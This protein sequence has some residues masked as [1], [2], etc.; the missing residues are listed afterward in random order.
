MNKDCYEII[1]DI[2]IAVKTYG[3]T[4]FFVGGVVRDKIMG[5]KS[6]DFD[7]E[8]HNITEEKLRSIL[9]DIT[10]FSEVGKSFG[11]FS[12]NLYPIDIALPRTDI[13]SGNGHRDFLIKTLPD[14]GT[15]NA[16]KRRDFTINSIMENVL[17][18][19]II[20][21]F[22]GVY[23]IKNSIIRHTSDE[24]FTQD[25]LRIL[26][27]AQFSARFN[28][29]ICNET[30]ALCKSTDLSTL[31]KERVFEETRKAL[32]L[33]KRPSVYFENLRKMNQL[34]IWF[35][36]LLNY[37]NIW[38]TIMKSINIAADFKSLSLSP[39]SFMLA[40][41]VSHFHNENEVISFIKNLTNDTAVCRYVVN[42]FRY[43]HHPLQCVNNNWE[44]SLSNKMFDNIYDKKGI[45]LLSKA[46]DDLS[47]KQEEFLNKRLDIYT[48]TINKPFVSGQDLINEGFL[49]GKD[50]SRLLSIA[51]DMH[52]CGFTKEDVLAQLKK[53]YI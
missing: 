28:L 3:G 34:D 6:N 41:T 44:I 46:I 37:S 18:G 14:M 47:P 40:V 17:T 1:K 4:A 20:D 36:K 39:I 5:I 8:V 32:L 38:E 16:A 53:E 15:F 52:L 35:F 13:K 27:A 29:N 26:R 12:L 31:S 33:S 43:R 10:P 48:Q 21:H 30:L 9:N 23:D 25:P 49:P 24:T 45:V 22:N 19:E 2:A 7:I 51:R 50:F 42:Q 11:I